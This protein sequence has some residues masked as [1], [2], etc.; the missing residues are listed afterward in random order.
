MVFISL[1]ACSVTQSCPTLLRPHVVHQD[2]LS[3]GI[4]RQEYWG[5]LPFPSL[6][7]FPDPGIELMSPALAGRFFATE[8]T[9]G[10]FN[11]S[12]WSEKNQKKNDISW[13]VKIIQNPNFGVHNKVSW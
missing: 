10:S 2:L 7:D 3:M 11:I 8:P 4:P 5:G 1:R 12:K 13:Y 9:G 6:R